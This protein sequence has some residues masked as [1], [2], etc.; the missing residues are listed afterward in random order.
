MVRTM[1]AKSQ[2]STW[3]PFI[4]AALLSSVVAETTWSIRPYYFLISSL[5]VV[6]VIL[7]VRVLRRVGAKPWAVLG[8]IV[9]LVIGQLRIIEGAV[10]ILFWAFR[11]LAP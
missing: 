8:V 3:G 6:N 7:A 2:F 10:T 5:G 11:G 9:G 4:A 1:S